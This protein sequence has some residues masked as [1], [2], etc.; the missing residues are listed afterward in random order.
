MRVRCT[1]QGGNR[2][3]DILYPMAELRG[4]TGLEG[5]S[6]VARQSAGKVIGHILCVTL[7]G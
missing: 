5:R 4:Q 3:R 6:G 7:C 1:R 2:W